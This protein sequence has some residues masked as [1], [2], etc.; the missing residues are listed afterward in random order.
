[1]ATPRKVLIVGATGKQGG[2][3][4]SAL[5]SL[6]PT[7]PPIHILALTRNVTSGGAKSLAESHPGVVTLV[8]G[9]LKDAEAVF[10]DNDLAPGSVDALFL[11]TLPGTPEDVIGKAWIDAALARGVKQVV[12]STVDRGGEPVSWETP[13]GVVHFAQ[14]HAIELYLRDKALEAAKASPAGGRVA[15]TV[16]RPTAFLD[17]LNKGIFSWIFNAMWATVRPA[18][19]PLQFVSTRD[20]GRFAAR[21]LADPEGWDQKAVS[22][23]GLEMTH[24]QA[25]ETFRRVVGR[26]MPQAWGIFAKLLFWL[27]PDVRNMF[28]WFGTDGYGAD[29]AAL[30]KIEPELQD[31]EG[32]LR[33]GSNWPVK[34]E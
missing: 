34:K 29:I 21:A 18:D 1:M 22:L 30:R 17:N 7:T 24:A 8:K 14:K 26:G 25:R 9:D 2:A 13:T 32:W 31:F 11:V 27:V 23:A 6:P 28:A 5:L 19:K 33:E 16:L 12:L 4:I 10:A 20:V 3:T 15:W